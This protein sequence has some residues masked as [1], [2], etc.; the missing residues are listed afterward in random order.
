MSII[1][2]EIL[3]VSFPSLFS[4]FCVK[5]FCTAGLWIK[6]LFAQTHLL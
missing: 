4:W 3:T 2:K 6:D 5:S 1:S